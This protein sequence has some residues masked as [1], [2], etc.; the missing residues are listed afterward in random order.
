MKQIHDTLRL[1]NIDIE[2]LLRYLVEALKAHSHIAHI[3]SM[4]SRANDQHTHIIV[5]RI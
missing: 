2:Y 5:C 3:T 1:D 4:Y